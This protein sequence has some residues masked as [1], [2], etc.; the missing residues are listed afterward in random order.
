[1]DVVVFKKVMLI[2]LEEINVRSQLTN[3]EIIR[4]ICPSCPLYMFKCLTCI[5][6]SSQVI[7][8]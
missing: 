3:Q 4:E 7:A 1:M 6:H 2:I 5:G 8:T